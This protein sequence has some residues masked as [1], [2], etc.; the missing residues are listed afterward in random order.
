M[1]KLKTNGWM[2]SLYLSA[3][4]THPVMKC[5]VGKPTPAERDR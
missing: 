3:L 1:R 5:Y 2:G 4:S